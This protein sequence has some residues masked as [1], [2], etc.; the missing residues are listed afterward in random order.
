M[1]S[2]SAAADFSPTSPPPKVVQFRFMTTIRFETL[3]P[4][5]GAGITNLG[6]AS[7]AIPIGNP[8]VDETVSYAVAQRQN[9]DPN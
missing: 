8:V 1:Q 9:A 5:I 2:E 3:P 4:E 7:S 6:I